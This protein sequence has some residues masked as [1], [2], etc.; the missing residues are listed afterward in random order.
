[1]GI[2]D[3]IETM[4]LKKKLS[5]KNYTSMI[6]KLKK[7]GIDCI[8]LKY[9]QVSSKTVKRFHKSKIKICIWTVPNKSTAKKYAK[10]GV[11]YITA[12]GAVF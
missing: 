8:S 6:S 9:T 4:Y 1:M 7:T 3:N 10:M 11:D 5:S 2:S 12:N